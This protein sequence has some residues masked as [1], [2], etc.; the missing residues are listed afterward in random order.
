LIIAP[1]IHIASDF[2]GAVQLF[3]EDR[4]IIDENAKLDYPSSIVLAARSDSSRLILEEGTHIQGVCI[5]NSKTQK[6]LL[7]P[8]VILK[9]KSKIEGQ[10]ICYNL[11]LQAQGEV[12]GSTF[13]N[14]LILKTSSSIYENHLMDAEFDIN[15]LPYNYAGIAIDTLTGPKR[16]VKWIY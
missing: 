2:S 15:P 5:A 10:L 7:Y 4:I 13:T 12:I 9:N 3:A 16:I 6:R 1:S 11:N 14:K 8:Q